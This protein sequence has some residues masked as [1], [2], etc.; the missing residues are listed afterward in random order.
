MPLAVDVTQI[1]F[2]IWFHPAAKSDDRAI[3]ELWDQINAEDRAICEDQQANASSRAFVDLRY[4]AV[5]EG[6]Q[7]FDALVV[8]AMKE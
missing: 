8:K 5:E 2:D 7:A 1:T 6:M 3:Y 4:E